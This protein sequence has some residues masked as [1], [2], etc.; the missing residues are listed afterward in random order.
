MA[1]AFEQEH[2]RDDDVSFLIRAFAAVPFFCSWSTSQLDAENAVLDDEL[3]EVVYMQ[4]PHEECYSDGM[5]YRL[6]RAYL[7][8]CSKVNVHFFHLM[9]SVWLSC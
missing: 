9:L 7:F 6:C 3:C 8:W 1:R 2:G 5:V 4:S